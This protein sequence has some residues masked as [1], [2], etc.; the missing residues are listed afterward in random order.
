[1][2]GVLARTIGTCTTAA[3]LLLAGCSGSDTSPLGI[4]IIDSSP[5]NNLDAAELAPAAEYLRAATSQGLVR[6]DSLGNIVPALAER[7]IVTDDGLS[8]IFRLR[9]ARWENG[10]VVTSEHVAAALRRRL[11]IEARS[12]IGADTIVVRDIRSM[13]GRVIEI[14]LLAP[15]PDLLRILAL[16]EL[17]IRRS[18][19]GTGPLVADRQQYW[20][21]LTERV[22]DSIEPEQRR[23]VRPL[24]VRTENAAHAIARFSMGETTM[25][26]GGRFEHLPYLSAASVPDNAVRADPVIGLF[27]LLA[28][29]ERGFLGDP[30]NREAIGLAIDRDALMTPLGIR[31][32]QTLTRIIP[33][34]LDRYTPLVGDRWANLSLDERRDLA[35]GR[36]IRWRQEQSG[37]QD[38]L[39][40]AMPEGPGS[41][42][43]FAR[44]RRDLAQ[45]GLESR[46]V[47]LKDTADLRLI[48]AVARHRQPSWFLNQLACSVR[49]VCDKDGDVL[50]AHARRAVDPAIRAQKMAEAELSMTSANI[51]IPLG[52]PVRFSL[53][54]GNVPGF[55]ITADGWHA[56]PDLVAIPR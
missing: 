27:G 4:S 1:M 52:A 33:L 21:L 5:V 29:N 10:D 31:Q 16:P 35:R 14:R 17:G 51:Y 39:R 20:T 41:R 26:L 36:V 48:D 56:L 40:I 34:G 32:W 30:A 37:S 22:D 19:R 44:L 9:N 13:T 24:Q 12:A 43:V 53:V 15:Q 50:L 42:L 28:V 11:N 55:A 46:M 49:P 6:L 18:G 47:G 8:Y 25:V 3:V 23:P 45:I 54:A 38:A 7:W 2:T